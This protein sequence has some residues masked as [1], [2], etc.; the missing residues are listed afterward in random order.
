MLVR[1]VILR[2]RPRWGH[3]PKPRTNIPTGSSVTDAYASPYNVSYK[4]TTIDGIIVKIM[5]GQEHMANTD[6]QRQYYKRLDASLMQ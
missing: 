1:P 6:R 2:P 3:E 4:S 5:A